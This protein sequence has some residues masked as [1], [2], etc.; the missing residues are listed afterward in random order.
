MSV[1]PRPRKIRKIGYRPTF[2]GFKPAGNTEPYQ[3]SLVLTLDELEAI[4][5]RDLEKLTQEEAAKKMNISQPTF[6]RLIE[7]AR[8][9][10]AEALVEGKELY[11]Q[12]GY[13]VK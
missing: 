1:M 13:W 7:G 12:G 8:Q 11:F 3:E 6:H 10:I 4:R 9:K 2:S 5:L